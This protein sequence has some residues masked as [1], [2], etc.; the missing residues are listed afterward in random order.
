MTDTEKNKSSLSFSFEKLK[1]IDMFS[2]L[3]K[4]SLDKTRFKLR[5]EKD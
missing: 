3:Q 4:D 1:T 2:G 5:A